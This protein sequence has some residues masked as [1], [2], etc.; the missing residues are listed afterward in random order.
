MSKFS[1]H[2]K[3]LVEMTKPIITIPLLRRSFAVFFLGLALAFVLPATQMMH[4]QSAGKVSGLVTEKGV[5]N[6]ALPGVTVYL[7]EL[8]S[9]GTTTDADGRYVLLSVPPG[10]YELVMSYIGYASL[11]KQEVVAYSGRTTTINGELEEQVF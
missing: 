5:K 10:T 6:E 11:V 9:K 2:L 8:P 1:H 4:A 3:M 7:K